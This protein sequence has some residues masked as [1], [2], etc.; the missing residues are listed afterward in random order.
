ML[1]RPLM[2]TD[3]QP[4]ATLM[5]TTPLW[6]RYGVTTASAVQ[7]LQAG[8]VESATIVVAEINN[9][10]AGFVWYVTHGAFQRGGYI[11]L[12]GVDNQMRSQGVGQAL[13]HHAETQMFASVPA[14][15]LL[16]SDFNQSAQRFYER[17]GYQ[18]IG[19]IPDFVAPGITEFIFYKHKS[20]YP[21]S[22]NS[23]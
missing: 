15:F 4:L 1:I 17:L 9:T 19:A 13:M 14:I 20:P 7:R 3:I 18:Q 21:G 22:A 10:P 11:M 5:A 8:L 23:A 2:P 12:I 16:V 6:Q